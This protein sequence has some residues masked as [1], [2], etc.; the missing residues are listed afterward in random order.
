[1]SR[2]SRDT[3]RINV[4]RYDHQSRPNI[5]VHSCQATERA[6]E[7]IALELCTVFLR[8]STTVA[9]YCTVY[10]LSAGQLSDDDEKAPLSCEPDAHT[11]LPMQRNARR[12]TSPV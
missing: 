5:H 1:M 11:A 4:Q 12:R 7:S 6:K 9:S 2:Q 3:E 10:M 8:L